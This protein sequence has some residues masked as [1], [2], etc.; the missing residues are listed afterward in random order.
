MA[1]LVNDVILVSNQREL[2]GINTAG[3][4]NS[5]FVGNDV[6][7]DGSVGI[8]TAQSYVGSGADLTD[9]DAKVIVSDGFPTGITTAQGTLYYD[10]TAL[11]QFTYYIDPQGTGQWVE[12]S[13]VQPGATNLEV[14]NEA[15]ITTA[16]V[17]LLTE[18]LTLA[19]T[20]N[21]ISVNVNA[22]S[23][24]L[25][26][27][28]SNDVSIGGSM[29]A[30]AYYGDGSN[31]T[32]IGLAPDAD[33][34]TTGN[35]QAGIITATEFY[36]D[37]SNLTG[38]Q[39]TAVAYTTQANDSEDDDLPMPFL[40]AVGAGASM[41]TD[42]TASEQFTY[43][44]AQGTLKCKTFDSLSDGRLKTNIVS[45]EDALG[46]LQE[47]RGVEYDWKNGSG[48]SVGIIAQ[49]VEAVYP[50]LVSN[51][52]E[53]MTVNYNGLVGLLIQAVNELAAEVEKLKS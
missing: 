43:N 37:G 4:D 46:K 18:T 39:G 15:G 17:N 44:P 33:I 31:L 13:P 32:G 25:T 52:E 21:E 22:G 8:I 30:N 7:I 48:A 35:I 16:V 24:T 6:Q 20:S 2:I 42:S 26:F 47:L 1:Y 10:S 9:I 50:Q 49:E 5:L 29:T 11:K 12:S 14:T 27:G 51:T 45:I 36:G 40:S 23:D 41:Y 34:V 53:R 3:V 19:G 28:L 38:I